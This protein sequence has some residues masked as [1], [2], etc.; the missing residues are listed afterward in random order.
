MTD[1]PLTGIRVLEFASIGPGPFVGMM[2]SDMGATVLRVERKGAPDPAPERFD[3]RGRLTVELDLKEPQAVDVC[4]KL[5]ERAE[6]VFEGNRPGVMER[7]G[8]GPEIVLA[9]NPRIVYGRMTGW[10]QSGPYAPYAGH[11]INYLSLSGALHAIGTEDRPIPPLNLAADYGGGAMM[12]V[13]GILAG[14]I[15]AHAG[16]K[17]QVIDAAMTDGAAYLMSYF[18]GLHAAGSWVD[19]RRA[20]LLDGGA[21][22]YDTYRCADATWISIGALEPKFYNLL[23]EKTDSADR[24]PQP[25][26]NRTSWRDMRQTL[27]EVFA[28]RTRQEW[29]EILEHTDACFAPVLSLEEASAHPHNR[30]RGTFVEVAGV[31]QPAP[32]PRFSETPT[33]IQW[34][35]APIVRDTRQALKNWDISDDVLDEI[36]GVR[37]EAGR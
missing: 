31:V 21:P 28:T 36:L 27:Q 35:P 18:Y 26:M 19:R 37:A 16:G 1:G 14:I 8:L 20:N 32:A 2:L 24:L 23:L 3:A 13:A 6:V 25:Q 33:R 10:G 29:C 7:L 9:R 34:P 12:L 22:F 30:A 4:L 5:C 11:D 17:G 15:H